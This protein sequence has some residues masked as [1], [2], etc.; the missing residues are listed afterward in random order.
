MQKKG[1]FIIQF[2][3][4]RGGSSFKYG[5]VMSLKHARSN[6]GYSTFNSLSVAL[7]L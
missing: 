5:G 2:Y 1:V 3:N 4:N 6:A 7:G